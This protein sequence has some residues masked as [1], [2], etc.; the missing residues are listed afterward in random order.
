[1]LGC[2]NSSLPIDLWQDGFKNITAVDISPVIVDKL[3]ERS[4]T[5]GV[6]YAV[7]NMMDLPFEEGSFDCVMEKATLDVLFV[8]NDSPWEPLPEVLD[9][10]HKALH[11]A[12]R[13]LCSR[14]RFVSITFAQPHFRQ[15][16]LMDK[17]YSWSCD[18]RSF[19]D[20]ACFE[21]FVYT[22]RK[23]ERLEGQHDGSLKPSQNYF[24]DTVQDQLD[25]PD[26]LWN[27]EL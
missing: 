7:G 10:L 25:H 8:E 18:V 27:I 9:N 20:E 15:P 2:G 23:G 26:F 12:H 6:E 24:G 3:R 13:V 5:P 11:E 16:L 21:Y 4:R 22:M 14:G 19:G 1:M 17:R